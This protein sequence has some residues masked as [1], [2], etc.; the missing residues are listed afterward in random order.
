M[1][2]PSSSSKIACCFTLKIIVTSLPSRRY[3]SLPVIAT[4]PT[5]V[6]PNSLARSVRRS[7]SCA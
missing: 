2:R 4:A 3:G 5:T 1:W 6:C 7:P